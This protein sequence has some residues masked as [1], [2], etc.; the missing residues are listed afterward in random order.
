MEGQAE[1]ERVAVSGDV[2]APR[3][4]AT[5]PVTA[6]PALSVVSCFSAAPR[7]VGVCVGFVRGVRGGVGGVRVWTTR[8]VDTDRASPTTAARIRRGQTQ[9]SLPC[10]ACRACQ[11][12]QHIAPAPL[13]RRLFAPAPPPPRRSWPRAAR[14]GCSPAPRYVTLF[15][16]PAV[17]AARVLAAGS[18]YPARPASPGRG[19][20]VGWGGD[21]GSGARRGPVGA[22]QGQARPGKLPAL[23]TRARTPGP[24][25]RP[26]AAPPADPPPPNLVQCAAAVAVTRTQAAAAAAV[27]AADWARE[28]ANQNRGGGRGG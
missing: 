17:A 26:A 3:R 25:C 9:L 21:G 22:R 27:V 23:R 6:V 2:R 19:V 13:R 18:V 24:C 12:P 7:S 11:H 5:W 16:P 8:A 4:P 20:G 1:T 14:G 28:P 10:P 15:R